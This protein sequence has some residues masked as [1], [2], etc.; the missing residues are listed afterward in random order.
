M[1]FINKIKTTNVSSSR[2]TWDILK[3]PNLDNFKAQ[4]KLCYHTPT[5]N[6]SLASL[7]Y[8]KCLQRNWDL[9]KFLSPAASVWWKERERTRIIPADSIH[10][11]TAELKAS[12]LLQS[13]GKTPQED[14]K[15][16]T[17]HMRL[18]VHP[19]YLWS[20]SSY[21]GLPWSSLSHRR[22]TLTQCWQ[23]YTLKEEKECL[24][25]SSLDINTHLSWDLFWR[26]ENY[27]IYM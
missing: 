16:T 10:P 3:V 15:L 27:K 1:S 22:P 8:N 21:R 6:I 7:F 18:A 4:S 26:W 9:T 13:D 25:N 5:T 11:Q 17:W 14:K 23:T 12:F 19:C 2:W 20:H 24:R